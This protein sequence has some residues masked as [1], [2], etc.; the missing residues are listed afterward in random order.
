ML[1]RAWNS[2]PAGLNSSDHGFRESDREMGKARRGNRPIAA[3]ARARSDPG[4]DGA[5]RE[6]KRQK[7]GKATLPPLPARP[8]AGE[9]G[10]GAIGGSRGQ[11][12]GGSAEQNPHT[13]LSPRPRS[14]SAAPA[15]PPWSPSWSHR[16]NASSRQ[17]APVQGSKCQA[18]PMAFAPILSSQPSEPSL[19]SRRSRGGDPDSDI[20]GLVNA[21]CRCGQGRGGGHRRRA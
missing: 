20:L 15:R 9:A 13:S 8:E 18:A 6:A 19:A 14:P 7:E 21:A 16:V 4:V 1:L 12:R 17:H 3:R 5:P 2:N 10:R 11:G